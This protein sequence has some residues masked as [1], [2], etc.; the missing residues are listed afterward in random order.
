MQEQR[1]VTIGGNDYLIHQFGARKGWKLGKKVAKVMLPAMANL[2]SED[3]EGGSFADMMG[4][5]AEHLDDLD[6][7]TI[8][9]LLSNVTVNKYQL[10]WDKHFTGKYGDLLH[11]LWEVIEF[12]FSDIFTLATEDTSE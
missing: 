9:E 1:T 5:I 8:D 4:S 12:N 2:Y 6:D 11:L 7:Q 3:G 10:D